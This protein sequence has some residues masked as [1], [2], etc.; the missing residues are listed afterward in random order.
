MRGGPSQG[1]SLGYCRASQPPRGSLDLGP[2][3]HLPPPSGNTPV[4]T[5]SEAPSPFIP[6]SQGRLFLGNTCRNC[7]MPGVIGSPLQTLGSLPCVLLSVRI[8][9]LVPVFSS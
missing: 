1:F 7:F 4:A 5:P 6:G 8:L 9:G 3:Q 2:R